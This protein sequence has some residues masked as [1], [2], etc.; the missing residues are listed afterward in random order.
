MGDI[1]N[2]TALLSYKVYASRKGTPKARSKAALRLRQ[3]RQ[4]LRTGNAYYA[5]IARLREVSGADAATKATAA[6]LALIT[7][8]IAA[9]MD[10][11]P[12]HGGA[13]CISR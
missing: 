7:S 10:H 12:R 9:I 2:L 6:A 1:R 5:E 8:T 4:D 11:E 13:I 3:A